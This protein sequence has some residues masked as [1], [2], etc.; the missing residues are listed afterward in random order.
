MLLHMQQA[1][2]QRSLLKWVII[3]R[4]LKMVRFY[5]ASA[6]SGRS[7][8][9]AAFILQAPLRYQQIHLESR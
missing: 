9:K 2:E 5:T 7:I 1:Y 6:N 4:F 3:L 8:A